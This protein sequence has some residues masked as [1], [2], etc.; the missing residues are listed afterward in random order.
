MAPSPSNPSGFRTPVV[1]KRTKSR[2]V[3]SQQSL[4][5]PDFCGQAVRKGIRSFTELGRLDSPASC[6]FQMKYQMIQALGKKLPHRRADIGKRTGGIRDD[7]GNRPSLVI[8]PDYLI[9]IIKVELP[10]ARGCPS[11]A[12]AGRGRLSQKPRKLYNETCSRI[13]GGRKFF[14]GY[15]DYILTIKEEYRDRAQAGNLLFKLNLMVD[16]DGDTQLGNRRQ[17]IKDIVAILV[18]LVDGLVRWTCRVSND[19]RHPTS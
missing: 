5:S 15:S 6:L 8:Q 12:Y 2:G 16:G 1:K 13:K 7:Q 19:A 9:T 3:F 17:S 10:R 18:S 14:R 4:H 11:Q